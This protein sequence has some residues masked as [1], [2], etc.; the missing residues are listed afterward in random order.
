MEAAKRGGMG[1]DSAARVSARQDVGTR[2]ARLSLRISQRA[3]RV[4]SRGPVAGGI[5][6]GAA[7]ARSPAPSS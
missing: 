7:R 3:V 1:E 2:T 6:D 5:P 4:L